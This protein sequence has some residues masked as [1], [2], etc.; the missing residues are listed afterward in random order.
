MNAYDYVLTADSGCDLPADYLARHGVTPIHMRYVADGSA[1]TDDMTDISAQLFYNRLYA[2]VKSAPVRLSAEDFYTFWKPYAQAGRSVLHISVSAA[3]SGSWKNG[4]AAAQRLEQEYPGWRAICLDSTLASAGC[5]L[6]VVTASE[7]KEKGR[8]LSECAAALEALKHS[9]V[10][11]FAV[12]DLEALENG[13]RP[14][15][16]GV[17]ALLRVRSILDLDYDGSLKIREKVRGDNG[18]HQRMTALACELSAAPSAQTLYIA[19]ADCIS[20]AM[21]YGN[22]IKAAAGFRDVYYTNVGPVIGVHTGKGLVSA[23]FM[24][25]E[26]EHVLAQPA[27]FQAARRLFRRRIFAGS[28]AI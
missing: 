1:Y 27:R 19:H 3:I 20:D 24:G 9:V 13:T 23:F 4:C 2:G 21:E 12:R 17:D 18:L 16:A 7:L 10:G 8:T 22:R 15:G 25:Q 28:P 6:L 5:G 11:L 26:R 14:K